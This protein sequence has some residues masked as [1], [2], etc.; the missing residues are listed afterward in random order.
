M[1]GP[2][3]IFENKKALATGGSQTTEVVF[4]TRGPHSFQDFA[5]AANKGTIL[6][7][8]Y[9]DA[10]SLF[11][12]FYQP[13]DTTKRYELCIMP[14]HFDW[15][16]GSPFLKRMNEWW[17]KET[18]YRIDIMDP[19]F[20]IA[21]EIVQ[22]QFVLC[23]SLHAIIFSDSYGVPNAH[24]KWGDN[25]IGGQYKFDDYYDSIGRQ[26]DWLDMS[27]ESLWKSGKVVTFVEEQKAK[28]DVS[29]MDLYPFWESCPFHAE[30]YNRTRGEHLEFGKWVVKEFDDLLENRPE[31]FTRFQEEMSRRLGVPVNG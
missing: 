21:D 15:D 12:W 2:G 23:S 14:H 10:G 19:L 8:V 25:V 5:S 17:P 30:G 16:M 11:S 26:H 7:K 28:Y 24:M 18:P 27:D 22:C 9:G 1:W 31:N 6:H 20:K 4:A 29:K 3:L 13:H